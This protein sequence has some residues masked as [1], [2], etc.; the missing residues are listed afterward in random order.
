MN[1]ARNSG[2]LIIAVFFLLIP[3]KGL[4]QKHC[5]NPPTL[6]LGQSSGTTCYM[7]SVT[8]N[9]NTF[10]G[11]AT[12]VTISGDGQGTIEPTQVTSTPFSFTY[13]PDIQDEGKIVTISVTTNNPR[14]SPCK[15]ARS[16]YQLSVISNPPAPIIGNIIQPTCTSSTGS[17]ALSGLPSYNNWTVTASPGGMTLDGSGTTATI[18]NLP[19]G[20]YTFSVSISGGCSSPPSGQAE[21]VDQ[22]VTPTP[23]LPGT[24][25]PPTCTLATGSVSMTGLPSSGTW[26]LTRYPG[27]VTTSGSGTGTTISGLPAGTFNFSL[28]NEAG[29]ISTLSGDVI[30]PAQPPIPGAPVIGTIIQPT[31]EI[32]TGSVTLTGLPSP[33]TWTIIRTPGDV[34]SAGSGTLFTAEGL[35]QG[36]YTFRVR[37]NSGCSSPASDTVIISTP[38]RPD[39]VITD[40]PPVCYPV[41]VDLTAPEIKVGST[42]GLTYTYWR[43]ILAATALENSANVPDGTYYIKGTSV[44]GFYDIKPVKVTIKQRPVSNAGPDQTLVFKFNTMLDATLGEEETGIWLLDSGSVIFNNVTDPRSAVSNLSTGKN[45]LSWIV[46]DG[47]CVADTDKVIISVGGP[48]IPTLITP[49]GDSRNEYFVIEGLETLGRTEL[50]V[51]DIRGSLIFRDSNYDN[52]WNGVDYNDK[53]LSNDTYFFVLK[54]GNGKSYKGYIVVRR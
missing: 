51:F 42:Q 3:I 43:D 48:V 21:I 16:T 25:T 7:T 22:P 53:P 13:I 44:S 14:G 52:K 50:T 46:S 28:T 37:N 15:S 41:T 29:C 5:S 4:G 31:I 49:N 39:V 6:S 8:V 33:G 40:P 9:D 12:A 17:V 47:V 18:P 10:G 2:V 35:E 1:D 20:T 38:G 54:S 34:T 32:L 19:A 45:V 24:I 26:T 11:S 27:T 23:P 30:I 36:S